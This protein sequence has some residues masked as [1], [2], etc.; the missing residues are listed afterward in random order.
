MQSP[1]T[2]C[3]IVRMPR[4]RCPSFAATPRPVHTL[5]AEA[6]RRGVRVLGPDV[7][8][9]EASYTLEA[10]PDGSRAI[11]TGLRAIRHLGETAAR[12][13]VQECRQHGP[14]RSLPELCRRIPLPHDVLEE[15]IRAGAFNSLHRNRRALL[16]HLPAVLR[17]ARREDVGSVPLQEPVLTLDAAPNVQGG[18]GELSDFT[19]FEKL[20]FEFAA[21]GFSPDQHFLPF[22]R[23][24]LVR[25]GY[26]CA[27][28]L[29]KLA[30]GQKVN[31]TGLV[32]RPDRPPTRSGRTVVFVT[33]EDET[34]LVDVTIFGDVYHQSGYHVFTHPAVGVRG[35]VQR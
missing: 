34:D 20:V 18:E 30:D 14:F 13:I 2:A 24:K 4:S 26:R 33:L 11:R 3:E 10:L 8:A 35:T 31:V 32:V 29:R 1:P 9:T 16:W 22:L 12:A 23:P 19:D 28:E 7:N 6:C 17:A 27:K 5:V 25:Q 21:M 15:L